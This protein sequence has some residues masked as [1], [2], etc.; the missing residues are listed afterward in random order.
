MGGKELANKV[1]AA[2]EKH[3][4]VWV[5]GPHDKTASDIRV[6]SK[7]SEPGSVEIVSVQDHEYDLVEGDSDA[8]KT[9]LLTSYLSAWA[10]LS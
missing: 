6:Q 1:V 8:K 10:N 2:H 7:C 5:A 9:P 4:S 3:E